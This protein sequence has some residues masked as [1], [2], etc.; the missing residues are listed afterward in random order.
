MVPS[1]VAVDGYVHVRDTFGSPE[2]AFAHARTIIDSG[3][4]IIGDFVIPPVN[5]AP[6]RDFQPLYFDFGLPVRPVAPADVARFTA[7]HVPAATPP[8]GAA[9]RLVNLKRLAGCLPLPRC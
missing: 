9:T 4:D 5:G 1:L 8:S 7:L 6:S 2:A 3:L